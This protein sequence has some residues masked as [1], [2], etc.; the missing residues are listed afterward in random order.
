MAKHQELYTCERFNTNGCLASRACSLL[1]PIETKTA[2]ACLP[3]L[4]IFNSSRLVTFIFSKRTS[5]NK[6][7]GIQENNWGI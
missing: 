7:E 4:C 5:E 6:G 3:V 1:I 2:I